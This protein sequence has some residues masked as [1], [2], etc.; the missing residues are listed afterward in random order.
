MRNTIA[1]LAISAVGGA[2][3]GI[4]AVAGAHAVKDHFFI[5]KTDEKIETITDEDVAAT[6]EHINDAG[7]QF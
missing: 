1:D 6:A 3:G 5:E 2:I 4:A 7:T